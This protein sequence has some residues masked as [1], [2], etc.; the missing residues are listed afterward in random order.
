[1]N[2]QV[3]GLEFGGSRLP[4]RSL[5]EGEA[6]TFLAEPGVKTFVAKL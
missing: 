5:S 3:A 2:S 4:N 1:M 6:A